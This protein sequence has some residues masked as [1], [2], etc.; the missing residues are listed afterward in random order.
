MLVS[1]F[2]LVFAMAFTPLSLRLEQRATIKFL[3]KTG[4]SVMQIC[5]ALQTVNGEA[6]LGRSQVRVWFNQF[7]AGD[8]ATP[9]KDIPRPGRPWRHLQY[10]K[11]IQDLLDKDSRL[12][13][14]EL[15]AKTGLSRNG[16]QKAVCVLRKLFGPGPPGK[17]C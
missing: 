1:V 6:A 10:A 5:R 14:D 15:S 7:H 8:M 3:Q 17:L 4:Q 12:S 11:R 16:N 9:T 13:L 2:L